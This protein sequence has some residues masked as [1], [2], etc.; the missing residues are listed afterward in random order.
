MSNP[1]EELGAIKKDISIKR[2]LELN[3]S[4]SN[5][6][7]DGFVVNNCLNEE[8]AKYLKSLK[9]ENVEIKKYYK[10]K[11][12]KEY[13]KNNLDFIMR[14]D[15]YHNIIHIDKFYNNGVCI[16]D[17]MHIMSIICEKEDER[18]KD[19]RSSIIF[20]ENPMTEM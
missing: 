9:K 10:I 3:K 11:I 17:N 13:Y 20:E 2:K 4:K 15:V 1:F 14:S 19:I 16:D 7:S 6:S 18:Y 8:E 5:V 12:R